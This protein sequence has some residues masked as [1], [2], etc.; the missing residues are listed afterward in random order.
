[1]NFQSASTKSIMTIPID[2]GKSLEKLLLEKY[3]DGKCKSSPDRLIKCKNT[4]SVQ[5]MP[6]DICFG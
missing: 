3:F 6:I 1:M 5:N 2:A 4:P